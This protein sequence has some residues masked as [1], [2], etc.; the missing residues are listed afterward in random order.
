MFEVNSKQTT[1]GNTV[2]AAA[3]NFYRLVFR[4]RADLKANVAEYRR[5]HPKFCRLSVGLFRMVA[6]RQ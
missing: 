1:P 2:V 5:T 4:F 3:P 6:P